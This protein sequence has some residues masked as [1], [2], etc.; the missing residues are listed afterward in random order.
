MPQEIVVA[1]MQISPQVLRLC[2]GQFQLSTAPEMALAR[3]AV[4]GQGSMVALIGGGGSN[5]LGEV[6]L[7]KKK[8]ATTP[9]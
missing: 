8:L 5:K 6:A 3:K 1:P 2:A 4:T 7:P 9:V